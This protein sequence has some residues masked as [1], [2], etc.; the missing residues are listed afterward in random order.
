MR[1]HDADTSALGHLLGS[2]APHGSARESPDA[3]G[4]VFCEAIPFGHQKS[5]GCSSPAMVR[6]TRHLTG[7]DFVG[8]Q[9]EG[10]DYHVVSRRGEGYEGAA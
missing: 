8:S 1:R 3:H 2:K 9:L 7:R 4:R 5:G 6:L 10:A